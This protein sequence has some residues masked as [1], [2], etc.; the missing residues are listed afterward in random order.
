[1]DTLLFD[2]LYYHI[3]MW[4]YFADVIYSM[5]GPVSC[6]RKFWNFT[7]GRKLVAQPHYTFVK[8]CNKICLNWPFSI[9]ISKTAWPTKAKFYV[10]PPWVA[11]TKACSRHLCHMTEMAATPIH[12]W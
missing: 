6:V 7:V 9:I 12:I 8:G 4:L 5:G 3:I 10:E 11:G 2:S 1:M